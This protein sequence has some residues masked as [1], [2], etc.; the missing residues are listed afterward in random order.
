M[1]AN[2]VNVSEMLGKVKIAKLKKGQKYRKDRNTEDTIKYLDIVTAFDIE[3]SSHQF[4]TELSDWQSW[5]YI[6]QWQFGE[7]VTVIG[8]TWEE[9]LNLVNSINA[10]LDD[11]DSGLRLMCYVHNLA[12]EFQFLSGIWHF[13]QDDIFATDVRSPLYCKMG[14]IEMRCSYR[15]SG[16]SLNQWAKELRCDHQ[17]L[18]GDLDYR[19]ERYSDT[20][21]TPQE[22]QYCIND[23]ICVVEC[24]LITLSSYDDTLY[25]IPYT[26]TGYIRRMV[27]KAIN[28]W[29]HSGVKTMQ[30]DLLTYDRMRQAFRGGDTHANRWHVQKIIGDVYSY[31]RSSSYP[32]VL[33][34][35][36]FPMTKFRIEPPNLQA[37]QRCLDTGRA[38]LLKWH[39]EDIRLRDDKTGDPYIPYDKC[40][41]L[42]FKEPKKP[43]MDNGRILQ[44][45][46]CELAMTDI[47]FDIIQEQYVWNPEKSYIEWMESSRYGYLPQ[48]LTDIIIKL[49]K[50][51]TA[52]KGVKGSEIE[53]AHAKALLNSIYGMMVQRIITN[54][55]LYI[56]D[57]WS[58]QK[59][60]DR[61][62][63]YSKQIE[64]A[65]SNYAWGVWTT[66]HARYRLQEGIRI[67]ETH[68]QACYTAFVYADT[69]SVKSTTELDFT[70]FNS[71]RIRAAKRSG[72]WAVDPKGKTHYMGV[73]EYEGKYDLFRTL[74]AKRY[75]VVI[76]DE[77][78]ITVAGVPKKT[79]SEVLKN[80]G[81]IEK[82]DFDYVFKDTGKTGAVY[83]DDIDTVMKVNGHS[84]HITR[85]VTIVDVDYSMT[86]N[87][88]Y[89]QLLWLID[90][91]LD[92]Y[93]YSDYNKRW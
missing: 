87:R 43:M 91:W 15:L 89:K 54:P 84:V 59:D 27:R 83:S 74:G 75:C 30:N 72:A 85:N 23:V 55:I 44:A 16:Y 8:R 1:Y 48:P 51:K 3:T 86:V 13:E 45:D 80:D 34:H 42:G 70:A 60:F 26:S 28:T 90:A 17:K 76:G 69:D 33:V 5:M 57:E 67:A 92:K 36:K 31:D 50:D 47:D 61:E 19:V 78:E 9:F 49:Y 21:L 77:L 66:A 25:S 12:F 37:F 29:T 7:Y 39:F 79:G 24:V 18:M 81:G 46:M 88:D 11:K 4:G 52:L 40:R 6:W 64:K 63:D 56:N 22:L 38:V 73:F 10:Y 20:V 41:E 58:I 14:H 2:N 68:K 53:Y 32:D 62:G 82:F 35:C 65:F 71:A 93:D